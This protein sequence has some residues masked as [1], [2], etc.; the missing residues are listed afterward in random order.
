VAVVGG[1]IVSVPLL[2]LFRRRCVPSETRKGEEGRVWCELNLSLTEKKRGL[3]ITQSTCTDCTC[4]EINA[5]KRTE[6]K[7]SA[8]CSECN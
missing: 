8:S 6:M 5:V 3:Y 1:L 4:A 7:D 2:F